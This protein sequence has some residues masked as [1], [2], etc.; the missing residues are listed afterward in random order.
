MG[1][2]QFFLMSIFIFKNKCMANRAFKKVQ[3]GCQGK[4]CLFSDHSK[5]TKWEIY[6]KS[7]RAKDAPSKIFSFYLECSFDQCGCTM[8]DYYNK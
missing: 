8:T 6:T 2:D 3:Y 5:R 4:N 7:Q 1:H